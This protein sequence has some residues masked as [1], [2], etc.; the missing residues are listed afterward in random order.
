[1]DKGSRGGEGAGGTYFRARDKNARGREINEAL[2]LDRVE[3]G[4]HRNVY[5]TD[6]G[7][8]HRNKIVIGRIMGHDH[9]AVPV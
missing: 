9:N 3:A 7:A 1:M 4:I 6:A 8:G 2:N 5:R